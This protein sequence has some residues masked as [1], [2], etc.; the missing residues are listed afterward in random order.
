MQRLEIG[1]KYKHYKGKNYRLIGVAKHSESLEE[2]VIYQQLYGKSK[3]WARPKK[4]FLETVEVEGK[5][6]P[7]FIKIK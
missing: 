3:L 6:V 1:A 7:R 2:L 5:K 4:M